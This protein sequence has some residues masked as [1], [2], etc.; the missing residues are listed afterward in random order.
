MKSTDTCITEIDGIKVRA[1][2]RPMCEQTVN[3]CSH[4]FR[5]NSILPSLNRR[6]ITKIVQLDCERN[7]NESHIQRVNRNASTKVLLICAFQKQYRI[8]QSNSKVLNLKEEKRFIYKK[9]A[10]P[11]P[12]FKDMKLLIPF[13]PIKLFL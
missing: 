10:N 6:I 13:A 2:L 3:L 12:V 9:K 8:V 11:V 5:N 4:M 7:L 1:F